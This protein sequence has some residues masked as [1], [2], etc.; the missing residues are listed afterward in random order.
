[1][2]THVGPSC[3]HLAPVAHSGRGFFI[4][5]R[6]QNLADPRLATDEACQVALRALSEVP[7]EPYGSRDLA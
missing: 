7:P 1:M 2:A 5:A 6:S 4:A 3:K